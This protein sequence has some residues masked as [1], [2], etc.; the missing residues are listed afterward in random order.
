MG[1]VLV[2]WSGDILNGGTERGNGQVYLLDKSYTVIT[3]ANLPGHFLSRTPG[4]SY[5]SNI[6]LYELRLT[7]KGTVIVSLPFEI[8][9]LL[10]QDRS[11]DTR[12][13]IARR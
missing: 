13:I 9:V 8:G 5:E 10:I 4:A 2:L 6:D 11:F 1:Q 7:A 12:L 3:G